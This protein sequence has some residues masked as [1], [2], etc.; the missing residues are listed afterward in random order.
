M[1]NELGLSCGTRTKG[2]AEKD[3]IYEKD[4]GTQLKEQPM[5]KVGTI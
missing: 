5:V 1:Q 4:T 3:R 2:S